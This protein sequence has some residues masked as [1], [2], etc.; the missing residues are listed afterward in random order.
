MSFVSSGGAHAKGGAH[1]APPKSRGSRGGHEAPERPQR[2]PVPDRAKRPERQPAAPGAQQAPPRRPTA[3][4]TPARRQSRPPERVERPASR[5]TEPPRRAPDRPERPPRRFSV[6]TLLCV[7][8]GLVFVGLAAAFVHFGLFQVRYRLPDGKTRTELVL[9]GRT[10]NKAPEPVQEG[11]TFIGWEDAEGALLSLE[12]CPIY[13]DTAFT[14]RMMPVLGAGGH[15]AYLSPDQRG[16]IQPDEPLL[17]GEAAEILCSFLSVD[18]PLGDNYSDV[19]R[20]AAYAGATAELKSLGVFTGDRFRPEE[21][22]T[23]RELLAMAGAF[24]PLLDWEEIAVYEEGVDPDDPESPYTLL[25]SFDDVSVRDPD[26]ALFCTAAAR[27]WVDYGPE[28]PLEP[29]NSLSRAE[30]AALFNR[31]LGRGK[32]LQLSQEQAGVLPDLPPDHPLYLEV[33]EAAVPHTASYSET[34]QETWQSSQPFVFQAEPG[35]FFIGT[36]MYCVGEDGYLVTDDSVD[37]FTFGPDGRFTSGMPELDELVQQVLAEII[38][39]DMDDMEKLRA[40]FDYTVNTFTYVK[41]NHYER[42]DVSW[43]EEEAYV[44]LSTGYNNCYGFAG[45]FYELA[46]AMGFEPTLI[47][48]L[49]GK[50][51]LYHAWVEFTVDGERRICDPEVQWTYLDNPEL[52]TPDLFMMTPAYSTRWKYTV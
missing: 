15:M 16:F 33:L 7:L 38:T 46:R 12:D 20:T 25:Y 34:G 48:G 22:V 35:R 50:N 23:R 6:T 18:L 4:Q 10:A 39:E 40:A 28:T 17:R 31:I 52:E 43:A 8:M 36:E 42:G 49:Y 11:Q 1:A 45:S 47:S 44:M 5:P 13:E 27:G 32:G 41:G 9:R 51:Y 24:I 26:Y 19:E 3:Q 2:E 29:N 21:P 30:A 14:A 37:G